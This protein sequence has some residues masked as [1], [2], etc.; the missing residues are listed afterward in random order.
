MSRIAASQ[1]S[2]ANFE[3]HQVQ[4]LHK[5]ERDKCVVLHHD[6]RAVILLFFLVVPPASNAGC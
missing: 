6:V 2:A 4:S 3:G 1:P 5:F